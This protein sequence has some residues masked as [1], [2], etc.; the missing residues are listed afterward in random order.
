[1][2]WLTL[3][4][5]CHWKPLE[6]IGNHW[7]PLETIGNL[8]DCQIFGSLDSQIGK[9]I[10]QAKRPPKHWPVRLHLMVTSPFN[11]TDNIC[12]IKNF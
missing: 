6:T 9:N 12:L 10:N 2:H 11:R 3:F 8:S 1:M 4:R 5:L 7:K